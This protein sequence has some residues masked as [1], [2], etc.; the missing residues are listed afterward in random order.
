MKRFNLIPE[1]LRFGYVPTCPTP[2]AMG[3][4][5]DQECFVNFGQISRLAFQRKQALSAPPFT[6]GT[7]ITALANWQTLKGAA[8]D[9]KIVVTPELN[10]GLQIPQSEAQ[11]VGGAENIGGLAKYSQHGSVR[12]TSQFVGLT[13]E[14][15]LALKKLE[16]ENPVLTVFLLSDNGTIIS[17]KPASAGSADRFGFPI[18]NYNISSVGLSG[19]Q[20]ALNLYNVSFDFEDFWDGYYIQ[21][22]PADFELSDL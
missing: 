18:R 7:E 4:I 15:Y 6:T 2:S 5:P 11:Y 3:D 13:Q 16:D 21:D 10:T 14:I 12:P 1:L 8:D 20:G 19:E 9:T 17:R 22:T